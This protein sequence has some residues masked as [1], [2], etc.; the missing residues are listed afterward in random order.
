MRLGAIFSDGVILQRDK[1]IY[2]FGESDTSEEI[3]IE[4]DDIKVRIA[5]K[6]GRWSVKLP[7][8]AAGGPYE[9]VVRGR[10]VITIKDILY[11]EVWIDNGQSNIEFEL[12]NSLGGIEEI[13]NADYSD[14]RFFKSIKAP[15]ID[16]AFLEEE[17]KLRWHKCREGDF[18]EMSG[19]GYFFAQKL[20]EYTGVPI[21][22]VDCYQGGTSISCWLQ[23]EELNSIPE[24]RAYLEEFRSLTVGQSEDEYIKLLTDYNRMVETHLRLAEEARKNN[25]G[26]TPEE[27]GEIAGD[28]PW[29]PP[30]GLRSAFRPGGLIE[31]MIKRI[32]PFTS[33]G[34]IYYQ[35]EEDAVR[36]YEW[37]K[38]DKALDDRN[39]KGMY[40]RLLEKLV[41]QYRELFCDEA[42]PVVIVQL[43]M[44]ISRKDV[45]ERKWAYI[46]EAQERVYRE[47]DS[48]TLAT[49]IDLGEYDN[50]HPVDKKSPGQRIASEVL[51]T[52]YSRD[53][54]G[55]KHMTLSGVRRFDGGVVLEFENTYGGVVL[56][57]NEL[58]D[59]RQE[60]TGNTKG[61][62]YGFEIAVSNPDGT[63]AISPVIWKVPDRISINRDTVIIYESGEI[64]EVR[65]GFFDYGKVNVYNARCVPLAPFRAGVSG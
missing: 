52:V 37:C 24:G 60:N 55:S 56:M 7:A 21:G 18:Q 32:A 28:Y 33:R 31:S 61:H 14:I 47:M 51:K 43:P 48:M 64:R 6:P 62:I 16:D 39:Y 50:V 30:M 46:R 8:H 15:V 17:K 40:Q 41:I 27:L 65:Y 2:V 59:I 1:E 38:A 45:D 42:L 63:D 22:I 34:I 58:V 5:V 4:I 26:I 13:K 20:H 10:D 11:G 12:R 9:M 29:P 25:P 23:E 53:D 19:I 57:E 49:L 3:S 36:N 35:G 54:V 44:Y